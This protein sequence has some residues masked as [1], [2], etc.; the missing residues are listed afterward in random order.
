MEMRKTYKVVIADD[1]ELIRDCI[2]KYIEEDSEIEVVDCVENGKLAF[3]VCKKYKVDVVL[4]DMV[5][6]DYDGITATKK[7]IELNKNIKVL[8]LTSFPDSSQLVDAVKIGVSGYITKDSS[9]KDMIMSIKNTANGNLVFEKS[10]FDGILKNIMEEK[11]SEPDIFQDLN[12]NE[13]A[14]LSILAI[15]GADNKD[16][17]AKTYL[18]ES[19]VRSI[20]SKLMNKYGLTKRTQLAVFALKNGLS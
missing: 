2:K 5:M 7:I 15:E 19:T 12:E 6:P 10:V 14:V 17:A 3:E 20:I 18:S 13:F 4:M 9:A 8:I 16:I 1:Q 11:K